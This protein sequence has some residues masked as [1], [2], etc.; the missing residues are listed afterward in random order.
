MRNWLKKR[1]SSRLFWAGRKRFLLIGLLALCLTT[2]AA[3]GLS[4]AT[5]TAAVQVDGRTLAISTTSKTVGEVLAEASIEITPYDQVYPSADSRLSYNQDIQV[6]K[7]FPVTVVADGQEVQLTTVP[8][9]VQEIIQLAGI[10]LGSLDR[11][12]PAPETKVEEPTEIKIVRVT[13]KTVHLD[14]EIPMPIERI[15]DTT[16]EQG[17][18]RTVQSGAKGLERQTLLVSYE[19]GQEVSRQVIGSEVIKPPVKKIIAAGVLTSV[20]R[21]GQRLDFKRAM[22]VKATAYSYN[23]GSRT[24]TGQRV[25]VGGIAVDP[26]VIKYG[27]RVYVEGYGY[28]VAN[29]CGGAIKGN[30]V[31]L[32]FETEKECRRWGVRNVK[33]YILE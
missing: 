15:E 27:T 12:T 13:Q 5:K 8:T 16:L 7:A 2:S 30:R 25:R 24:S 20:S 31:D 21:G 23:A 1:Y 19:D 29:D 28:A 33:L 32:F 10:E 26:T 9:S 4:L 6:I 22:M 17:I 11:V 3:A 18:Q 14:Q